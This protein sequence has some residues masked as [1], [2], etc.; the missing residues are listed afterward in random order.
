[1]VFPSGSTS[2]FQCSNITIIDDELLEGNE[3]FIVT[4]TGAGS[5]ALI[6]GIFS[7]ATVTVIDDEGNIIF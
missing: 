1:M 5:Y 7:T 3:D 6:D 2:E 4:I